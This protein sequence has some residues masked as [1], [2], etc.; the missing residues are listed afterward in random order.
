MLGLSPHTRGNLLVPDVEVAGS[1]PAH[2]GKPFTSRTW[3]RNYHGS[4][5]AHTG[6]PD[7][8]LSPSRGNTPGV[9]PRTDHAGAYEWVYPRTYGETLVLRQ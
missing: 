9:Y 7:Q 1:I 2:T 4:I 8:G 3:R 5:P 6:K